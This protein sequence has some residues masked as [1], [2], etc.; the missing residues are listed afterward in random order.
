MSKI[1]LLIASAIFLLVGPDLAWSHHYKG[2]PHNDYF[3]NYPQVPSLEFVV[4]NEKWEVFLTVFNF[5]GLDL[6]NVENNKV[7]RFYIFLYDVLADKVYGKPA[8]FEIYSGDRLVGRKE[9]VL[10][11]QENTYLVQEELIEQ[12][13]LKLRVLFE[14]ASGEIDVVEL[15]FQIKKSMWQNFRIPLFI[16]LFFVLIAL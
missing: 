13:D 4:E 14:T 8:T 9:G 10:P 12:S 7:V 5:D 2:L 16:V 11:E 15:P 1:V 6:E 3:E